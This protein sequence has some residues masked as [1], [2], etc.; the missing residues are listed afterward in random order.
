[1][2][3][4]RAI[5]SGVCAVAAIENRPE[6]AGDGG[7]AHHDE[8]PHVVERAVAASGGPRRDQTRAAGKV[9][10]DPEQDR[11]HPAREPNGRPNGPGQRADR[12]GQKRQREEDEREAKSDAPERMPDLLRGARRDRQRNDGSGGLD[13]GP[14]YRNADYAT[15]GSSTTTWPAA[16]S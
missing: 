10:P 15:A 9:P 8:Q 16:R 4:E 6:E 13:H 1:P 2:H 12:E 7:E 3:A 11:V 5:Q 14:S